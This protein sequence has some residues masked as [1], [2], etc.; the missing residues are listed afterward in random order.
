MVDPGQI[1]IATL[2]DDKPESASVAFGYHNAARA[3]EREGLKIAPGE[4]CYPGDVV[5]TRSTV[6]AWALRMPEWK[7]LLF[8]D[9]DVVPQDPTILRRMID[10]AEE[11]G[12]DWIGAPYPRKRIPT[13][14]PFKMHQADWDAHRMP[15][16]RSCVEVDLLAIGFTLIR[17]TALEKM[18]AAHRDELWFIDIQR[19]EQHEAVAIFMLMFDTEDVRHGHRY[20]ELL[21]EDYSACRRWRN[22]G[23]KIQ[24]YVG[25]GSPVGHVG[26]HTFT[27]S[28]E[29]LGRTR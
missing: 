6:V 2:L 29:D 16:V 11:D 17:R 28:V 25:P 19:A 18:V 8:W 7:W 15:I 26:T 9:S 4:L 23:G 27:G 12:H 3:L 21:S 20:R 5:R 24:M 22:L 1:L 14:F 10:L 13:L